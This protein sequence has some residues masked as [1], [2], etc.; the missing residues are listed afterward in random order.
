MELSKIF[1]LDELRIVLNNY[2]EDWILG[3]G[4]YGIVYNG[5]L[6]DGCVVVIKKLRVF[7]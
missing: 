1:F 3:K 5:I 6:K 7:D 2:S 4:G